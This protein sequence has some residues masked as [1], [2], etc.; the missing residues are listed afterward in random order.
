M[1]TFDASTTSKSHLIRLPRC[2]LTGLQGHYG[3][4][5]PFKAQLSEIT[6]KSNVGK[7][8]P[9]REEEPAAV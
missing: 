1:K 6:L 4:T 3:K 2:A 5:T 7:M 8:A 9:H